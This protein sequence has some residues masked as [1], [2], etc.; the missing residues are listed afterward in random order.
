MIT[1]AKEKLKS[2]ATKFCIVFTICAFVGVPS[3]GY[4]LKAAGL[5]GNLE[6]PNVVIGGGTVAVAQAQQV[7]GAYGKTVP[8]T[9]LTPPPGATTVADTGPQ[10][11]EKP[12]VP[13]KVQKAGAK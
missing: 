12:P 10:P 11:G 13:A 7:A 9:A 3:V 1:A 8:Q 2:A 5:K 4:G 6:F